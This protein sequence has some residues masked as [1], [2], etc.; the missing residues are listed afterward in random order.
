MC[1]SVGL[2]SS[3]HLGLLFTIV[4]G[5][6]DNCCTPHNYTF[7]YVCMRVSNPNKVAQ[8]QSTNFFILAVYHSGFFIGKV[9]ELELPATVPGSMYMDLLENGDISNPYS[10]LN[11]RKYARF[12]L[13]D[14]LYNCTFQGKQDQY[15][16]CLC[17]RQALLNTS[18]IMPT[19]TVKVKT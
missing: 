11:D 10:Y 3:T 7:M 16:V 19:M 6:G 13:Q 9:D 17:L 12:S 4:G 14:W 1:N 18:S 2:C 15:Y 5:W 8:A